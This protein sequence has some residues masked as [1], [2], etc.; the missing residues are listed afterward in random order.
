MYKTKSLDIISKIHKIK[1]DSSYNK[2][3]K[4]STDKQRQL[5]QVNNK[6][7]QRLKLCDIDIRTTTV[8]IHAKIFCVACIVVTF[9][10]N[11]FKC[12]RL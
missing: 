6:K 8:K 7:T 9:L 10:I 3:M 4:I 11:T 5:A 12:L 2:N 1:N